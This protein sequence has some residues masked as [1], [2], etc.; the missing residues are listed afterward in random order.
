MSDREQSQLSL[1]VD[2]IGLMRMLVRFDPIETAMKIRSIVDAQNLVE[3]IF[4]VGGW[5]I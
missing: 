3:L 1:S 5:A 2:A 4:C